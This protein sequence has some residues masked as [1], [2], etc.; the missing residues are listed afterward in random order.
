MTFFLSSLTTDQIDALA[1]TYCTDPNIDNDSV[2]PGNRLED[3]LF[4]LAVVVVRRYAD[5]L[6]ENL[7]APNLDDPNSFTVQSGLTN[8]IFANVMG[9]ITDYMVDPDLGGEYTKPEWW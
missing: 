1:N 9:G 2:D 3:K 6:R 7:P 5:S 8:N 4:R